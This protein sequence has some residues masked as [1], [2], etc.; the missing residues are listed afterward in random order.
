MEV[1]IS[2]EG[3]KLVTLAPKTAAGNPASVDGIPTWTVES[4]DVTLEIAEDGL[5][6]K[7]VS[8]AN[9]SSVVKITADADLGEGV[10]A[11]EASLEVTVTDA[12]ANNL[13]ITVGEE[14][15]K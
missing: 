9:G 10:R 3:K 5:S 14:E 12:E 6:A 11:I 8:G 13:G 4:G 2:N 7:V 15:P 1:R